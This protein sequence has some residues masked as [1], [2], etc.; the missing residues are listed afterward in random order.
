MTF[1]F[2][3]E[4]LSSKTHSYHKMLCQHDFFLHN[5]PFIFFAIFDVCKREEDQ[6]RGTWR[7]LDS[8]PLSIYPLNS[9][10]LPRLY[11][12]HVKWL[13]GNHWWLYPDFTW[14]KTCSH[15]PL[16]N[17]QSSKITTNNHP[18]AYKCSWT[19]VTT[20]KLKM[21]FIYTC[22][23]Y[24]NTCVNTAQRKLIISYKYFICF[25]KEVNEYFEILC[26]ILGECGNIKNRLNVNSFSSTIHENHSRIDFC[27]LL[28]IIFKWISPV[29]SLDDLKEHI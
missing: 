19:F 6:D 26:H 18:I 24:E 17:I 9:I 29:L 22:L 13:T 15:N 4:I 2:L 7:T 10:L 5:L 1:S 20:V 25:A 21:L 8:N 23:I 11:L 3:Y 27:P 28:Y 16:E 14:G 12:S